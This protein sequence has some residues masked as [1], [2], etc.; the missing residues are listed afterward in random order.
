MT[1]HRRSILISRTLDY[2]YGRKA[3]F[4][5]Y[6]FLYVV[7]LNKSNSYFFP[8]QIKRP[9]NLKDAV[10]YSLNLAYFFPVL[11]VMRNIR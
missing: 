5:I 10:L 2:N 3:I 8:Y 11:L 9:C 6:I 1:S 7:Y 4:I